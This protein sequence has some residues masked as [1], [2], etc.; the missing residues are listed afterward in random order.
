DIT[1]E[2]INLKEVYWLQTLFPVV[3]LAL[4]TLVMGIFVEPVYQVALDAADQLTN[5]MLYVTTVLGD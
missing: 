4:L 5:P 1:P 3:V 2:K